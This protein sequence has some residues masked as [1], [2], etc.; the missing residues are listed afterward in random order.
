MMQP[1]LYQ[2]VIQELRRTQLRNV[3]ILLLT[4]LCSIL[5]SACS[6]HTDKG[7]ENSCTTFYVS[8]FG[9]DHARGSSPG[10]AWRTVNRVNR[11]KLKAGDSV[12][13][14]RGATWREQLRIRNSGIPGKPIVFSSYGN[15]PA[16][17]L[18]GSESCDM[19]TYTG[20]KN[21]WVTNKRFRKLSR[22]YSA[23]IYI[24]TGDTV[25]WGSK[26]K[27]LYDLKSSSNTPFD[28]SWHRGRI[29]F[30]SPEDPNLQHLVL[31]ASQRNNCIYLRNAAHINID[32]LDLRYARRRNI[33]CNNERRF[34]ELH[35]LSI[36]NCR[37]SYVG[38]KNGASAY[39]VFTFYSDLLIENC[40][41][42]D[43][44]RRAISYTVYRESGGLHLQNI[45]I[46]NNI[47]YNGFHTTAIDCQILDHRGKHRNPDRLDDFTF[48]N[49][50]IYHKPYASLQLPEGNPSNDIFFQVE[51]TTGG[52]SSAMNRI[53][54]YNNLIINSKSRAILFLNGD[55][56]FIWH[57]TIYG[58]NQNPRPD[59]ASLIWALVSFNGTSHVDMRNNIIYGNGIKDS[60]GDAALVY[61]AS[62]RYGRTYP[63][64]FIH[65][66]YNLFFQ[67]DSLH[68]RILFIYGN[69]DKENDLGVCMLKNPS[70][71]D[72]SWEQYLALSTGQNQHSPKPHDPL[73]SDK[74]LVRGLP[75]LFLSESSPARNAGIKIPQVVDD[76]LNRPL[77]NPPDIG[78]IQYQ[79]N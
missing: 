18:L 66:D 29:Y 52:A 6:L 43:C 45:L 14:E 12:L 51:D 35:G 4:G 40:I 59:S 5:F 61:A 67:V 38:V 3:Y 32:S 34:R 57:N 47:F 25:I 74:E 28:W 24:T 50:L 7:E 73:F 70:G 2:P 30:T 58:S 65:F 13:F 71:A 42:H 8:P 77:N 55:S 69:R 79:S 62:S 31:E 9:N 22:R 46:Q 54:I 36:R 33:S 41:F 78:A 60:I 10:E 21:I 56:V 15:G 27:K 64:K 37:I 76:Y 53:Y 49:N 17:C 20:S 44:G 16:P 11:Q 26:E 19:F 63:T 75:G 39:G 72:Y 68:Q 1:K 48:R 23:S